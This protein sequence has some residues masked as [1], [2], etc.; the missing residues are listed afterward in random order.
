VTVKDNAKLDKLLAST[1]H[2]YKVVAGTVW[3]WAREQ[4]AGSVDTLFVDEAGQIALASVIAA[5][6]AARNIVLLGDPRQLDQVLQGSHPPGAARS[7][8]GHFLGDAETLS[9]KRGVFLEQTWRMHPQITAYTSELFYEGRLGPIDGLDRQRIVGGDDW[10]TGSGLRWCAVAHEGND[11]SSVEEAKAVVEICST[12]IG[13]GWIDRFG[14]QHELGV[15]DIRVVSPY[16]AHRLLIDELL[17]KTGIEG[18]QVGTVDKFQGQEA[19]VSIYTMATSRPEDAPRG[20]GFLYSLNRL[21]V[22]TSRA[23][24]LAIVVA[25][26]ELLKAVPRSPDQLRMVNGLCAFVEAAGQVPVRT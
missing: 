20:L 19:P 11:N 8:L 5:G 24:A 22:A 21:N 7:A 2:D 15:D 10:L 17:E 3:L 23:R 14:E 26:P 18:V 25:S 12:L 4:M 16:N 9:P 1:E 13:R 6:G